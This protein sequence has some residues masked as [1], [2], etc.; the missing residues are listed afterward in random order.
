MHRLLPRPLRP[1]RMRVLQPMI[2]HHWQLDIDWLYY[3]CEEKLDD[4]GVEARNPGKC[5][6]CGRFV[7]A[8]RVAPIADMLGLNAYLDILAEREE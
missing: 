2:E 4:P 5:Y 1:I 3:V 6:G 8:E 7:P